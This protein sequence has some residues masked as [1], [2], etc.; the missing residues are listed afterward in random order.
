MNGPQVLNPKT[1]K[2]FLCSRQ[3]AMPKNP[4]QKFKVA[5]PKVAH[6]K[7]VAERMRGEAD[8][9]N[10]A[11]L[12]EYLE[13]PFQV[14]KGDGCLILR[15]KKYVPFTDASFIPPERL[16][17]LQAKGYDA[18]LPALAEYFNGQC[19]EVYLFGGQFQHLTRAKPS[20]ENGE[21]HQSSARKV[22]PG[23]WLGW[24]IFSPDKGLHVRECRRR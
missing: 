14:P 5:V 18:L 10:T 3:A 22:G 16:S 19:V 6:R 13:I 20:I 17:Q 4:P 11:L 7:R 12:P 21:G 15:S 24:D 2:V 23:N 1:L 8:A 9:G